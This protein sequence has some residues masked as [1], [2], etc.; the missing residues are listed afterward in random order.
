M[1]YVAMYIYIYI[2]VNTG[3]CL[4]IHGEL[5]IVLVLVPRVDSDKY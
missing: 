1:L 3:I 2:Y 5:N 4:Y